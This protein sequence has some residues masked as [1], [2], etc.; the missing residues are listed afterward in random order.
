MTAPN[1][2]AGLP[3]FSGSETGGP[4]RVRVVSGFVLGPGR[5]AAVGEILSLPPGQTREWLAKGMVEPVMDQPREGG[6]VR[7]ASGESRPPAAS[8][9]SPDPEGPPEEADPSTGAHPDQSDGETVSTRD[10]V[11]DFHKAGRR[12]RSRGRG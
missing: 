12:G 3:F 4:V 7:V 5:H 1:P 2:L 10:P 9:T 8:P 6:A 11:I